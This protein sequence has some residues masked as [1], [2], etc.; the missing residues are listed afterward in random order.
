MASTKML[1]YMAQQAKKKGEFFLEFTTS[2][3]VQWVPNESY[4]GSWRIEWT[5]RYLTENN[6]YIGFPTVQTQRLD[7]TSITNPFTLAAHISGNPN[8]SLSRSW[9]FGPPSNETYYT[10]LVINFPNF[11][12]NG[13]IPTLPFTSFP[14]NIDKTE[15]S[16]PSG[17]PD[18]SHPMRF[19]ARSIVKSFKLTILD[20]TTG[21]SGVIIYTAHRDGYFYPSFKSSGLDSPNIYNVNL[22]NRGE[23]SNLYPLNVWYD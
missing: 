4:D 22:Y 18:L 21:L 11:Y 14:Y 13:H 2:D 1:Y 8:L 15:N 12:V 7:T 3:F 23:A 19:H 9:D 5:G 10:E 6:G 16:T 20:D 17:Y